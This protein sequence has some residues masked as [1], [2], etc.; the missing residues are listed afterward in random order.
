MTNIEDKITVTNEEIEKIGLMT[1]RK[2][3]QR[4]KRNEE[5]SVDKAA[6]CIGNH[7][8]LDKTMMP[9]CPASDEIPK[10]PVGGG[11]GQHYLTEPARS[12]L[13]SA[14]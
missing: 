3:K 11:Y 6:E 8:L 2:K 12:I 9:W 4:V 14:A 13:Q 5:T 1:G 10:K 7:M